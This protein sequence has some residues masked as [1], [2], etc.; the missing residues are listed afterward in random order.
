MSKA[1]IFSVGVKTGYV[2]RKWLQ[3]EETYDCIGGFGLKEGILKFLHS[4]CSFV[5]G[6][7]VNN[8]IYSLNILGG[9]FH[10]I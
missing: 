10:L 4:S 8:F 5:F 7:L 2:G 6:I 9:Q 3:L 1:S